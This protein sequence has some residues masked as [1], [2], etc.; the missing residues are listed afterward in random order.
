[1]EAQAECIELPFTYTYDQFTAF[2]HG[3][4]VFA[5]GR[6]LP[7]GQYC[8]DIMN[9]DEETPTEIEQRALALLPPAQDLLKE[10]NGPRRSLRAGEAERGLCLAGLPGAEDGRGMQLPHLRA[11]LMVDQEKWAQVLAPRPGRT[12]LRDGEGYLPRLTDFL[13]TELYR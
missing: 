3:D 12:G 10:K 11:R 4:H 1:M 8:V 5:G 2:F 6:D 13:R 9:L 7:S